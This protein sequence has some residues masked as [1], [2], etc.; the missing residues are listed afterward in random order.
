[1]PIKILQNND[2]VAEVQFICDF[3][4]KLIRT[5]V[6]PQSDFK[7]EKIKAV[8]CW[9]CKLPNHASKKS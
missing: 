5:C 8:A 3:Y 4:G 9:Q 2:R 6:V 7:A 1:M